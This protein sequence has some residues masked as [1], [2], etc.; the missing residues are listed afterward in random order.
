MYKFV[1]LAILLS[2]FSMFVFACDDDSNNENNSNN[3]PGLPSASLSLVEKGNVV[4]SVSETIL[5]AP[6]TV[7]VVDGDGNPLEG[8]AVR[9][10]FSGDLGQTVTTTEDVLVTDSNGTAVFQINSNSS[11]LV[12]VAVEVSE[13]DTFTQE[14]PILIE[15]TAEIDFDFSINV[16]PLDSTFQFNQGTYTMR[17]TVSDESGPIVGA[18]ISLGDETA[19]AQLSPADGTTDSQGRIISELTTPTAG[20]HVFSVSLEGIETAKT[21]QIE[22]S[23]PSIAG[24]VSNGQHYPLGYY[25]SRVGLFRININNG[26]V[27]LTDPV[28]VEVV[29]ESVCPCPEPADYELILPIQGPDLVEN[30]AMTILQGFYAVVV[31]DD[32]ND[33]HKWDEG[34]YLLGV[35]QSTGILMFQAPVT[36]TLE[37]AGW[38]IVNSYEDT[39]EILEWDLFHDNINVS[40]TRSPVF[41]PEVEVEMETVAFTEGRIAFAVVNGSQSIIDDDSYMERNDISA[42]LATG[43][44]IHDQL[45]TAD[46]SPITLTDVDDVLTAQEIENIEFTYTD[47]M[48]NLVTAVRVTAFMY[49]D[50]DSSGSWTEGDM[51][52]AV[53]GFDDGR[54]GFIFWV[55]DYDNYHMFESSSQIS[56][57]GG[58]LPLQK[59]ARGTVSSVISAGSDWEISMIPAPCRNYNGTFSVIRG[60]GVIASGDL[61]TGNTP[62]FAATA[63][64]CTNCGNIQ[65][66]DTIIFEGT[67]ESEDR[68]I[69]DFHRILMRYLN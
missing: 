51:V 27:E 67:L 35:N 10:V 32:L 46:S 61:S 12:T 50:L 56:W 48:G 52:T 26:L 1:K 23:G 16:I 11:G 63:T 47:P 30:D 36:G 14:T 20:L 55:T 68:A 49:D 5:Q 18:S 3:N 42:L 40:I 2:L 41:S 69:V 53:L 34:E 19:G 9:P 33:N 43:T 39:F 28:G 65:A 59:Q 31:Y 66:G 25:S 44:I 15:A 62:G 54:D 45:L 57:H 13:T 8:L 58:Y 37:N 4:Y 7:T 38:N 17:F 64:N 6:I 22:L 60:M 29:S 21:S 24:T